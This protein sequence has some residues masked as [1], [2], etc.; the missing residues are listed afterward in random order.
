M[1]KNGVVRIVVIVL[2]CVGLIAIITIG[3]N[4]S[5]DRMKS[6][7]TKIMWNVTEV[8]YME[9][10][11]DALAGDV[12]IEKIPGSDDWKW[13]KSPWDGNKIPMYELR[14]EYRSNTDNLI[15]EYR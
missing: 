15:E 12:R 3:K 2:V 8:A 10:Q 7:I 14:S 11:I 1:I 5:A 6:L 13:V 4:R 9:G